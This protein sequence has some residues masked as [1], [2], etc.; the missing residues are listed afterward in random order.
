[1]RRRLAEV[2]QHALPYTA[3]RRRSDRICANLCSLTRNW[4]ID[5]KT[6]TDTTTDKPAKRTR[7]R[8]KRLD[9]EVR[10]NLILDAVTRLIQSSQS[11]HFTLDEVA[12]EAGVSRPLV[13]R[14]FPTREQIFV[15][16]LNREFDLVIGRQD[17][18]VSEETST[19]DAHRIY[20]RRHFEYLEE[21]GRFY[22]LLLSEAQV[23]GGEAAEM[24]KRFSKDANTYWV[25]RHMET[26]GLPENVA[27]MGVLM[28]ISALRGAEGSLRLGKVDVDEASDFWTRFILAG[29]KAVSEKYSE[30]DDPS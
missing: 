21:R 12:A 3:Y 11:A 27:R 19:E 23:A 15:A 6:D 24:A 18:L 25:Q 5:L 14:Y 16:L 7:Q 10:R 8:A 1:M 30:S 2:L 4:L 9:P 22:H 20:I 29:W 13:H 26:Y 28:T 17:G